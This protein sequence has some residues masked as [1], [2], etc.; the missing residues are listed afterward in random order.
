M[1]FNFSAP[2]F[3]L[4]LLGR[5]DPCSYRYPS[6][7]PFASSLSGSDNIIAFHTARYSQ[8]P[9]IVQ[10]AG[11]GAD[12]TAM[13]VVADVIKVSRRLP[14]LLNSCRLLASSNRYLSRSRR[15]Y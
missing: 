5:A 8:R 4:Y 12:V 1:S 13:G 11:A 15:L 10:G 6:S 7:H 3:C 9:L 2:L 14:A